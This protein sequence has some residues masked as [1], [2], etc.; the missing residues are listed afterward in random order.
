M[1]F[2]A[3][4]AHTALRMIEQNPEAWDQSEW[5]CE[6][7][8]CFAG[9]VAIAAGATWRHPYDGT[10][11]DNDNWR[12]VTPDGRRMLVEDFAAEALGICHLWHN[13]HTDSCPGLPAMKLFY[14]PT[15]FEEL[16]HRVKRFEEHDKK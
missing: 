16:K 9:F 14:C 13:Y 3:E 10:V 6:T 2:N 7:S 5:R 12:V 1:S 11:I 4:L 15:D 8:Y